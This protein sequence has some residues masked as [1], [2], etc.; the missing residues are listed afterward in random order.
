MRLKEQR[1][2]TLVELM[3]VIVLIGLLA[4]TVGVAVWPI[5]FKGKKGAA[6]SQLKS[7]QKALEIYHID[8]G[9]YPDTLATLVQSDPEHDHPNGYLD[10]DE[11]PEDP[12]QEEY[13]YDGRNDSYRVWSNGPDGQ[14][15]TDDDLEFEHGGGG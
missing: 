4:G 15:G 10:T 13:G 7:F 6:E 12:W 3:V 8:H 9:S 5:L 14:E 11:L 2:F 1:G